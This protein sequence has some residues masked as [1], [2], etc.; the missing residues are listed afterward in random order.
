MPAA[1][2]RINVVLEKPLYAALMKLAEKDGVSLSMKARD[3]LREALSEFE[4]ATLVEL[5]AQR[6]KSFDRKKALTHK[7][8]WK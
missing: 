3:L 7:Q 5:A 4:D 1:N 8:A 6:A 2:P